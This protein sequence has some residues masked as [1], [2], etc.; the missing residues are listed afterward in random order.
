[1]TAGDF[2]TCCVH[3]GDCEN[4]IIEAIAD[5][6]QVVG[7][8]A[9]LRSKGIL[10]ALKRK[11]CNIAITGDTKLP[12]YKHLK[13]FLSEFKTA[14]RVVGLSRGRFRSL[15]HNKFIVGLKHGIPAFV[16]TGSYNYTEHKHLENVVRI[17]DPK[18]ATAFYH[19]ALAVLHIGRAVKK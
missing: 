18:C 11:P 15:M 2:G 6:D 13:P 16:V 8:V 10:Q 9:W 1:M 17:N 3:F 12:A 19:E 5:A 14:I 4:A 7:C